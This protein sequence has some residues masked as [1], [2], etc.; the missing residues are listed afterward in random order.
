VIVA[1]TYRPWPWSLAALSPQQPFAA[2][3]TTHPFA[4]LELRQWQLTSGNMRNSL[5][6]L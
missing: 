2:I 3:G 1:D 6:P 4:E 5:L